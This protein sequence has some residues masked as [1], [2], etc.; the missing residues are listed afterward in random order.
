[1][2]GYRVLTRPKIRMKLYTDRARQFYTESSV[3]VQCPIV[4]CATN[5]EASAV[6]IGCSEVDVTCSISSGQA[7]VS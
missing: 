6:D 1:M 5:A 2:S 7:V 3:G 4:N